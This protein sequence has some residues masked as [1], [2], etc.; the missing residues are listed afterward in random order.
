MPAITELNLYP[1]KSCA[2]IALQSAMA[3]R[4]GLMHGG[5]HDREWMVVDASGNFLTQRELPKMACIRPHLAEDA[6]E[7]E[8]PGMPLLRVPLA[9]TNAATMQ[10]S[11]W[12]HGLTADTGDDAHAEWFS[13]YL[14]V[15]CRL[16]RFHKQTQRIIN[17]EWTSGR[18]VETLFADGFPILLI[19]EASLDDL[20]QKLAAQG[21]EA[22]PM[23]RFRPNL[24]I[25]GIEAFEEDY[26]DTLQ[27]GAAVL[28]PVKPCPRCPMPSIDQATGTFGPDPLDI[29]QSYR[30]NPKVDG[31]ITFGMNVIL[32]EGENTVL[33]V[34]QE[35]AV[36]LAF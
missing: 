2:G 1:I 14:G 18:D 16:V 32:L 25:D 36:E 21:R 26:L 27:I 11:V 6:L 33:Q 19:S 29:L 34:G 31:G 13:R 22:L 4:Y 12:D 20:N 9:Q 17:N 5:V 8:A 7:I 23:N 24:V 10:V 30:V 28:Q 35:V 15:A 3:T